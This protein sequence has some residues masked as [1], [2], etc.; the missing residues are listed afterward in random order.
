MVRIAAGTL[1][2][3]WDNSRGVIQALEAV[4]HTHLTERRR[5]ERDVGPWHI[6]HDPL[7]NGL[8]VLRRK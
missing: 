8:T 1:G 4:L 7:C 3:A 2:L 6:A 5:F